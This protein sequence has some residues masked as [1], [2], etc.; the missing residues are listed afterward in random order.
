MKTYSIYKTW[1]RYS[2]AEQEAMIK[3]CMEGNEMDYDTARDCCAEDVNC[4]YYEDD[5][6]ENGN[7]VYSSLANVP[8]VITGSLGLWDGRHEI[9]PVKCDTLQEALGKCCNDDIEDIE[10]YEDRYGNFLLNCYHHD[11]TNHFLIKRWTPKGRRCLHF[12]QEV[13]GCK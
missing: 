4:L 5:F 13:F 3:D 12:R 2:I 6:G 11:G 10:I 8:V 7:L 1:N 9:K